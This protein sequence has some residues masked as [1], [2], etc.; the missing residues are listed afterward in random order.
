MKALLICHLQ[1]MTEFGSGAQNQSW[2]EAQKAVKKNKFDTDQKK[3][4]E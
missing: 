1:Y 2:L 4:G 3:S